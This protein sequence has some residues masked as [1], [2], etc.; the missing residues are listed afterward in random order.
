MKNLENINYLY[1]KFRLFI[2]VIGR[3]ELYIGVLILIILV[4]VLFINCVARY[5]FNNP[6][7]W[8][9]EFAVYCFVWLTFLGAACAFNQRKHIKI[10]VFPEAMSIRTKNNL[11]I[12]CY[13][14]ILSLT[15]FLIIHGIKAMSLQKAIHTIAFPIKIS[16]MY[17][18]AFPLVLSSVS[19]L[20]TCIFFIFEVLNNK[21]KR[22]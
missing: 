2:K 4:G 22:N 5:V 13:I 20:I 12:F 14:L 17:F 18:F 16:S 8:A 19:M 21:K 6:L 15:I 9:E 3:I 7:P 1:N 10:N 11:K